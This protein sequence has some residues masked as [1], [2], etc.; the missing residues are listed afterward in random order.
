MPAFGEHLKR[1][2]PGLN[3]T[4]TALWRAWLK[5]NESL[6][7]RFEYDVHVGEGAAT[8]PG[9]LTGDEAFDRK[10]REAWRS[11]TQKRIDCVGWREDETWVFEVE[12]RA[13][14]KALGQLLTYGVLFPKS[15]PDT[16]YLE[17]AIVCRYVGADMLEALD[18]SNVLLYQVLPLEI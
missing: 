11:V 6:F 16:G 4:E 12:D 2:Y 5:E 15:N 1:Y 14:T 13:G 8:P 3:P 7:S 18:Q 17:L 9:P 10:M